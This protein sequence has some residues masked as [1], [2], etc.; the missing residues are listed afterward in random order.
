LPQRSA[1]RAPT[2]QTKEQAMTAQQLADSYAALWNETDAAARRRAIAELWVPDGEHYVGTRE[3]RG[4]EALEQR[5]IGSHEKNVRDGGHRFR[6]A[7]DARA[8]R[9]LVVFQ[10]E[11]LPEKSETVVATGLE[12]LLV[13]DEGRIVVDY[14]FIL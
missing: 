9:N 3:V 6:A 10:W 12:I 8:L 11:M 7:Q 1:I 2:D 13:T 4:Y 5:V 14:Q